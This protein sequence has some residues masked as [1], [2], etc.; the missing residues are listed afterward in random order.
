MFLAIIDFVEHLS[1]YCCYYD[2]FGN[3]LK[4]KYVRK[5]STTKMS[6]FHACR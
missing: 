2:Y 4:K 5:M 3:K 6:Y 1:Y